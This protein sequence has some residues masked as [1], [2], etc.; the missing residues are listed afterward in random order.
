MNIRDGFI[1]GEPIKWHSGESADDRA[2]NIA[3]IVWVGT[4]VYMHTRPVPMLTPHMSV[5]IWQAKVKRELNEATRVL[6]SRV[7][8]RAKNV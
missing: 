7:Y 2:R 1:A 8:G 3:A 5:E 4:Q 6:R